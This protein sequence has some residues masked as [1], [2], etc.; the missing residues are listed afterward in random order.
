MQ[1]ESVAPAVFRRSRFLILLNKPHNTTVFINQILLE[2]C[3]FLTCDDE[4]GFL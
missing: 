4:L 2:Q 3:R 1:S